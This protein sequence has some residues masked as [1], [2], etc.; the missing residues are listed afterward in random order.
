MDP[1]SRTVLARERVSRKCDDETLGLA[2]GRAYV[3]KHDFVK[4]A[5]DL[6]TIFRKFFGEA[7]AIAVVDVPA[8]K[9]W[10]RN[11][12]NQIGWCLDSRREN[13]ATGNRK[14]Q[15]R[16]RYK[17][18][19]VMSYARGKRLC[20]DSSKSIA[21]THH[22]RVSN[23]HAKSGKRVEVNRDLQQPTPSPVQL[24]RTE[25]IR[26]NESRAS[27]PESDGKSYWL[28]RPAHG[29]RVAPSA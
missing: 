24:V 2:L 4:F 10:I 29:G 13:S 18:T 17:D 28:E 14:S 19:H 26:E 3:S 23:C 21:A 12:T 15:R 20:R 16:E 7:V 1:Y 5:A 11:F 8:S 25:R 27:R 6:D 9:N 22:S